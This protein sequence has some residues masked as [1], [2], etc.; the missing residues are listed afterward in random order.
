MPGSR[1]RATGPSRQSCTYTRVDRSIAAGSR[2][3]YTVLKGGGKDTVTVMVYMCGADLESRS[4]MATKDLNEM[5]NASLGSRVNLIVYTGGCSSW[6]NNMVSSS[7]NQI[8]QV[9][10]GRTRS[11]QRRSYRRSC[12]PTVHSPQDLR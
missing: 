10:N 6:R 3:K 9:Q 4:A 11:T 12:Q 7:V 5:L 2:D 1:S 8:W